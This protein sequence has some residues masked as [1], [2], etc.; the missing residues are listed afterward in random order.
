M[1]NSSGGNLLFLSF[2]HKMKKRDVFP[3]FE[4]KLFTF[5]GGNFFFQCRMLLAF[6]FVSLF[7][8]SCMILFVIEDMVEKH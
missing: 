5:S 8:R 6:I 2:N 7:W 1:L 3:S 4:I